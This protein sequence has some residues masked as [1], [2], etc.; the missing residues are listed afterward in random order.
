ML[1]DVAA[2]LLLGDIGGVLSAENYRV[3]TDRL[4]VP[5][6]VQV[7]YCHLTVERGVSAVEGYRP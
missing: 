7:L 5:V 1:H 4:D 2:E 3:D 6:L